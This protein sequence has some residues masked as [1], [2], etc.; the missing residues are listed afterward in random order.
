MKKSGMVNGVNIAA[1][2]VEQVGIL[3]IW[4]IENKLGPLKKKSESTANFCRAF[5]QIF[6]VEASGFN[7]D[8]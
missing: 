6:W 5:V 4:I 3:Y 1:D 7:I 8:D 2:Y